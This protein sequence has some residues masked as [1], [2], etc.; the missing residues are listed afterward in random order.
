MDVSRFAYLVRSLSDRATRRCIAGVFAGLGFTPLLGLADAEA[1]KRKKKKT[2]K[3]R[4]K[5]GKKCIP[6]SHC[7]KDANCPG[8]EV[9]QGGA[10]VPP[11]CAGKNYCDVP[12]TCQRSGSGVNCFCWVSAETGEPFC[13]QQLSKFAD[14]CSECDDEEACVEGQGPSCLPEPR[15]GCS[16]P[17]PDPL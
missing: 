14:F 5:C 3:G 10:C 16:L 1:K 8:S 4:K 7:C 15:V 17:C 9:C 2:C 12:V 11:F 13:G 6:K